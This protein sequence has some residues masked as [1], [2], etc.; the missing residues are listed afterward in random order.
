M[1]RSAYS[2][3]VADLVAATGDGVA[4]LLERDGRR[5]TNV[6][7]LPGAACVA[8]APD[9]VYAGCHGNGLWKSDDAGAAWRELPPAFGATKTAYDRH[10]RWQRDGTWARILAALLP[11]AGEG[12]DG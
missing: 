12:I 2:R 8:V 4:I 7:P 5:Q 9:A 1:G 6:S 3:P 10:A 11:P